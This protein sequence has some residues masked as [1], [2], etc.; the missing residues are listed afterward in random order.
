[1]NIKF[2]YLILLAI[3]IAA[4]SCKKDNYKAPGSTLSGRLTYNG[5]SVGV[6]Y[7]QV[8]FQL[9]QPGYK[10]TTPIGGTFNDDGTYSVVTFDGNYKFTIQANQGPFRWKELAVGRDTVR[11][12]LAGDQTVN[13]EVTPYYMVRQ[14]KTSVVGSTRVVTANFNIEKV[15]TDPALAKNIQTVSLFINKTTHVS[16]AAGESVAKTDIAGGTL[17]TNLNNITVT[18]TMPAFVPTQNY[19]FARIGVR[20][21][22]V[23][24]WYYS[25]VRKLTF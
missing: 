12:N 1:M 15:I 3:V 11:I 18:A 23:E 22:G 14:L 24:D 6:E 7:N 21:S 8:P 2:N 25:P 5:D 10:L 16:N 20:I 13:I 9:Y 4:V 17:P 19:V